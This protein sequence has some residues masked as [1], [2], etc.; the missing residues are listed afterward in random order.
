MSGHALYSHHGLGKGGLSG[1]C[2]VSYPA[3]RAATEWQGGGQDARTSH[4][5]FLLLLL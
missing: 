2:L 4:E 5:S 1:F 3:F